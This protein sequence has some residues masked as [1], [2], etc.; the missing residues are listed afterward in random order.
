M[1]GVTEAFRDLVKQ[2]VRGAAAKSEAA[3][4]RE[5]E[6]LAAWYLVLTDLKKDVEA[7][8]AE[9]RARLAE[10]TIEKLPVEEYKARNAAYE[11]WRAAAGYFK[12]SVEVRLAEARLLR[13]KM[14]NATY[15]RDMWRLLN[16]ASDLIDNDEWHFDYED[17]KQRRSEGLA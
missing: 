1:I 11:R 2:D 3:T 6:N 16:W 13:Q 12:K 15:D 5:P 4:L 9:R 7:Q 10:E 17:L 14:P 8:F